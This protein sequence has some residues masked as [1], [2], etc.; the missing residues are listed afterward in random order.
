MPH[1][2]EKM[3]A[4]PGPVTYNIIRVTE[5]LCYHERT[6]EEKAA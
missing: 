4:K 6:K 5:Q 1:Y 3:I 2:K